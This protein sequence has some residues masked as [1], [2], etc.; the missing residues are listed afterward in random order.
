MTE[1]T[2]NNL[3]KAIGIFLAVWT[4]V[5]GIAFIIQVWRIYSYGS[6]AYT[7]ERIATHFRQIAV[8]V[9]IWL[10]A[11]AFAGVFA[12]IFPAPKDKV[13][14]YVDV[15]CT[16]ARLNRRLPETTETAKRQQKRRAVAYIACMVATTACC[17]VSLVYMV[18][19][20]K[21]SAKSGF[22]AEHKEAE[23]IIRAL[24]WF[25]SA[26]ALAV[27]TGYFVENSY[28]KEITVAKSTIAENAKQ[29]IKTAKTD[30]KKTLQST[31]ANKLAFTKSKWFI[32]GVRIAIGVTAVAFIIT[33][34]CNG[35]VRAVLY[36][37]I[38]ICSQCIGIG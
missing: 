16:L 20:V 10:F 29:G 34:V 13:K 19:S 18:A 25:V 6:K 12:C 30:E 4:V 1:K 37:A 27:G 36:K 35:G 11:V 31:I 24:V 17:V 2:K 21:L 7:V 8:P 15:K 26:L 3:R 22:L 23:R 38:T 28:K 14:P 32:L 33:G 5:V 9:Y